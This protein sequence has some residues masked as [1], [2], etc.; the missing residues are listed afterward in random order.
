MHTEIND[1]KT[2]QN[3]EKKGGGKGSVSSPDYGLHKSLH[4]PLQMREYTRAGRYVPGQ[5][6]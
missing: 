6:G 1:S 5:R 3:G 2:H 4:K